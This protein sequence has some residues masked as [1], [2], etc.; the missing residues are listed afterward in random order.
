MIC[1]ESLYPNGDEL[2]IGF[3]SATG[4][5]IL[6]S[7]T[8]FFGDG[9]FDIAESTLF[10]QLFIVVAKAE[11]GITVP[12]AFFFLP[13]KEY[14]V[15]EKMFQA[16]KDLGVTAP[17]YFCTVESTVTTRRPFSRVSIMCFLRQHLREMM[18]TSRQ[19]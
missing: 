10:K 11:V 14:E 15:Y 16:L 1:C 5:E 19:L 12:C 17:E 4:L 8:I 9:T 2:V 18:P 7:S 13:N 3:S 6:K